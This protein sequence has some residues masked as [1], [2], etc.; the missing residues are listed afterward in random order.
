MTIEFQGKQKEILERATRLY[1]LFK[2]IMLISEEFDTNRMLFTNRYEI[3]VEDSPQNLTN[4]KADHAYY[5]GM[6]LAKEKKSDLARNELQKID[7]LFPELT[8]I[9]KER[10]TWARNF[11]YSQILVAEDSLIKAFE[12]RNQKRYL[13]RPFSFVRNYLEYNFPYSH[14]DL[15][16]VYIQNNQTEKAQP[17]QTLRP[18]PLLFARP[19]QNRRRHRESPMPVFLHRARRK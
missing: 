8:P 7:I 14:D 6:I 5:M 12:V 10:L 16:Q 15:A 3:L 2:R 4:H 18:S 19:D 1:F 13:D 17:I 9:A 11:L